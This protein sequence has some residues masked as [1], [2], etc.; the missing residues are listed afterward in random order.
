MAGGGCGGGGVRVWGLG[1]GLHE[2]VMRVGA[3]VLGAGVFVPPP[4]H[5][6]ACP[7]SPPYKHSPCS[8]HT[9]PNTHTCLHTP[10]THTR[11]PPPPHTHT[12]HTPP[13]RHPR[14]R[15]APG[16]QRPR[17]TLA[18]R[19]GGGHHRKP[20]P[21]AC[22]SRCYSRCRR[23]RGYCQPGGAIGSGGGGRGR[24]HR[25]HVCAPKRVG[26]WC[27]CGWLW[28]V[29]GGWCLWEGWG[30]WDAVPRRHVM[31]MWRW[32]MTRTSDTCTR[33]LCLG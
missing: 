8:G 5:V 12:K 13:H 25:A 4:M 30:S 15:G 29:V 31:P 9:H 28:V 11:N 10:P 16:R 6:R 17:P 1:E 7:S 26:G 20:V 24:C 32:E 18:A 23:G 27:V 33:A 19:G 14:A 21:G 22:Y 3:V 2:G